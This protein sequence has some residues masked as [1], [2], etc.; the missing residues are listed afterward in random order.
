[1]RRCRIAC[2]STGRP[3]LVDGPH[4]YVQTGSGRRFNP[5]EAAINPSARAKDPAR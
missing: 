3:R 4:P 5:L 1:M 2:P